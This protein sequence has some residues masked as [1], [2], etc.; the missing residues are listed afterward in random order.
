MHASHFLFLSETPNLI[1]PNLF[2]L[3]N[4]WN[5]RPSAVHPYAPHSGTVWAM[6]PAQM[7]S[8]Y[9]LVQNH[10]SGART[11]QLLMLHPRISR[12]PAGAEAARAHLVLRLPSSPWLEGEARPRATHGSPGEARPRTSRAPPAQF[13][14]AGAEL[15]R[16]QLTMARMELAHT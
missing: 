10:R 3:G 1:A 5:R 16:A 9:P 13:A 2:G 11:T 4:A 14:M 15:T 7:T 12:R 8:S 6:T